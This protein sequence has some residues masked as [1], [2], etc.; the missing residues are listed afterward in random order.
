MISWISYTTATV[1]ATFQGTSTSGW[2]QSDSGTTGYLSLPQYTVSRL[3]TPTLTI[4]SRGD[5]NR[6][7]R[8]SR[9]KN[10]ET[11]SGYGA[12]PFGA[13]P[14]VITDPKSTV[15]QLTTALSDAPTRAIKQTT[16]TGENFVLNWASTVVNGVSSVTPTYER[17]ETTIPWTYAHTFF[18]TILTLKET[19]E[20]VTWTGLTVD[21][22]VVGHTIYEDSRGFAFF[23]YGTLNDV[24]TPSEMEGFSS[25]NSGW[26]PI[27]TISWR[28]A[29][30]TTSSQT[31]YYIKLHSF[32][33][34]EDVVPIIP[35]RTRY[36]VFRMDWAGGE[37][38]VIPFTTINI[39]LSDYGQSLPFTTAAY[40][41]GEVMYKFNTLESVVTSKTEVYTMGTQTNASSSYS[42][43]INNH[44][45]VSYYGKTSGEAYQRMTPE[46]SILGAHGVEFY[47][48]RAG[49]GFGRPDLD[50]RQTTF[51]TYPL[52]LEL[53][54]HELTLNDIAI[55][56]PAVYRDG[57][58]SHWPFYVGQRL[59]VPFALPS[60]TAHKKPES[61]GEQSN[62]TTVTVERVGA[63]FSSSWV[64]NINSSRTSS[65]SGRAGLQTK[66][67]M[68]TA[69]EAAA[70]NDG[71]IVLGGAQFPHATMTRLNMP[72]VL[73]MTTYNS[74]NSGTL[75]SMEKNYSAATTAQLDGGP[76]LTIFKAISFVRGYGMITYPLWE[77]EPLLIFIE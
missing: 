26:S 8:T 52:F 6:W 7:W 3:V 56:Y 4:E 46:L 43:V 74:A 68:T 16:K 66:N 11:Q 31:H 37:G 17:V 45:S 47:A 18:D 2:T 75:S 51:S 63:A 64:W 19:P 55:E 73:L 58:G 50:F 15:N 28:T 41:Y 53:T 72:N 65:S 10:F 20:F 22:I 23:T 9:E 1:S 38:P 42:R 57:R 36:G 48:A 40:E 67:A 60:F 70:Y 33:S 21:Q 62:W 35:T 59:D 49:L 25:D 30:R 12:G 76:T 14:P 69:V 29:T 44:N 39:S 54:G 34:K 77:L 13:W 71:S 24:I 32:E 5:D 27:S 61:G